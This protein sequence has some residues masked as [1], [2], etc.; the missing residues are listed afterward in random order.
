MS[1]RRS[2]RRKSDGEDA[3]AVVEG[4]I[5]MSGFD[6]FCEI[7]IG[8]GDEANIDGNGASAADAFEFLFLDGAQNFGLKLEREIPDF[9]EEESAVV[10]QFETTDFLRDGTSKS[11]A[12][13]AEKFGFEKAAGD[14]SSKLTKARSRRGLRRWMARAMS[15]YRAAREDQD[16]SVGQGDI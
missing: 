3:E 14:G 9:I 12:F 2:R 13:M 4:T 8:G 6:H 11:A 5:K 7:A 15:S 16:G 10:R 1:S